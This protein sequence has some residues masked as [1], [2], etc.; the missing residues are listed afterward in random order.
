MCYLTWRGLQGLRV[1]AVL[2]GT[3]KSWQGGRRVPFPV[4]TLVPTGVQLLS[5]KASLR[6]PRMPGRSVSPLRRATAA[7]PQKLPGLPASP[8]RGCSKRYWGKDLSPVRGWWGQLSP[9][10]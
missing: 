6:G 1:L 4:L 9:P 3:C 8:R 5:G 7:S 2:L 10:S